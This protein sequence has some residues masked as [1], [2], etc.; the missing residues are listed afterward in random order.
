V[1]RARSNPAS[2]LH[3]IPEAPQEQPRADHEHHGER[4]FRHHQRAARAGARGPRARPRAAFLQA[5]AEARLAKVQQR[6]ETEHDAGEERDAEGEDEHAPVER[7]LR[8]PRDA[9]R[10][11][12]EQDPQPRDGKHDPDDAAEHCEG[13]PLGD[14]L[15]QQPRAAGAKRAADGKLAVPRV[16]PREEQVGEVR[17]CDEQDEGDGRLQHPQRGADVADDIRLQVVD[18]KAVALAIGNVLRLRELLPASQQPLEVCPCVLDRH[19]R[20]RPADEIQE[21]PATAARRLRV[22]CQRQ[23]QLDFLIV[24][25]EAGR[26]HTDYSRACAVDLQDATEDGGVAV[27]AGTPQLVREDR[28]VLGTRQRVFACEGPT[29][30]RVHAKRGHQLVRHERGHGAAGLIG[31]E[32]GRAHRVGAHRLEGAVPVAELEEFRDGDPELVEPERGKLARDKH[33]PL[34]VGI[35]QRPQHDTVHEAEDRAVG[36]DSERERRDGQEREAGGFPELPQGVP[37]VLG[38]TV[39]GERI[40][41]ARRDKRLVDFSSR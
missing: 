24:H 4:D 7:D 33:Q 16:G 34:R 37:N 8:G 15:A 21:V 20:L 18:P 10:V 29:E 41:R 38:H 2:T 14:E 1:R 31:A 30:L 11:R 25:I 19:A 32:V 26:H 12:R 40:R 5:V 17:A 13:Q 6:S 35:R 22:D 9:V 36:A 39:H 3:Q 27:E 28:H 23:P